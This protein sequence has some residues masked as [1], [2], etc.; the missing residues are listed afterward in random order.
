MIRET[1][2][3]ND[4]DFVSQDGQIL[5]DVIRKSFLKTEDEFISVVRDQWRTRPQLASVGTCC[6]V[7]VICNRLIYIANAG[8]S[9]V[10]LGR[11]ERGGRRIS[12]IQLSREHNVNRESIREELRFLYLED[13][14]IVVKRCISTYGES[15]IGEN[16]LAESRMMIPDHRKRLE[17]SL[18]DLKGILVCSLYIC[19]YFILV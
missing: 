9:R 17:S 3:Y 13:P 1:V 6:L 8:D 5:A 7:G 11:A 16:V 18:T 2:V 19:L 4:N 15:V 14:K 12:A 10:V